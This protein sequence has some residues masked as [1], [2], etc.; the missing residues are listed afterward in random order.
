[1]YKHSICPTL[2]WCYDNK[3]STSVLAWLS[4]PERCH[5]EFDRVIIRWLDPEALPVSV[6]CSLYGYSISRY[7]DAT[8]IKVVPLHSLRLELSN[9]TT[10]ERISPLSNPYHSTWLIRFDWSCFLFGKH[11][12]SIFAAIGCMVTWPVL[13]ECW[14]WEEFSS[15][16]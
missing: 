2:R 9:G 14:R 7:N 5:C 15:P 12:K 6:A 11:G 4:A 8:E 16:S 3:N 10:F 13:L 1:M